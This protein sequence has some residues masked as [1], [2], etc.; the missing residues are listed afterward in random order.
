MMNFTV[1]VATRSKA[2]IHCLNCG[3]DAPVVE[4][5]KED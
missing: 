1:I 5:T 2:T 4:I 3:D